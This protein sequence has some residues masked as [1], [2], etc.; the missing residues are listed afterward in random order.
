MKIYDALWY[1]GGLSGCHRMPERSFFINGKQF[2]VCA[3]CT[4]CFVGYAIGLAAAFATVFP[5]AISIALMSV[6]LFDWLLQENEIAESSNVRRFLT[7][8]AGGCGYIQ[9]FLKLLIWGVMLL[10]RFI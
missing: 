4:G 1:L 7:G 8:I 2:P 3:R 6:M 9:L 10:K 5:V